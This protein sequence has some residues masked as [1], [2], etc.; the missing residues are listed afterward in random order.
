MYSKNLSHFV[1][2]FIDLQSS[3]LQFWFLPS[4]NANIYN[5]FIYYK[6]YTIVLCKYEYVIPGSNQVHY[7]NLTDFVLRL[8]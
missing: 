1:R 5:F 2:I 7:A 6:I 4:A 8:S 3:L